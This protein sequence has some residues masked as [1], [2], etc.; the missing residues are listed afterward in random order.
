MDSTRTLTIE[1]VANARDLGGLPR[2]D[3]GLTAPGSLLRSGHLQ[4]MTPAGRQTL[5]RLGVGLVVDLRERWL[6]ESEPSPLAADRAVAYEHVPLVPANF[7]LPVPIDRYHEILR[8]GTDGVRRVFDLLAADARP[9]LFH[10]HS[11]TG[12][13]GLLAMLLLALA[14]VPPAEIERDYRLSF[15][16]DSAEATRSSPVPRV[17]AELE[18]AGGVRGYLGD[19]GV[20]DAAVAA[21]RGRLVPN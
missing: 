4:G 18:R 19:L 5:A 3:G 9:A 21:V 17:L 8:V 12:R 15:P 16:P 7:P 1:G 10:C 6:V 11:G 13:T 2:A 20:A 14:E